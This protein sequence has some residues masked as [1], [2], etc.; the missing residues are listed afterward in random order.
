MNISLEQYLETSSLL[1]KALIIL[2]NFPVVMSIHDIITEKLAEELIQMFILELNLKVYS[3]SSWL[4][5]EITVSFLKWFSH[6]ILLFV[7]FWGLKS[8]FMEPQ[9]LLVIEFISIGNED[10]RQKI[11]ISWLDELYSGEFD[12]LSK[13]NLYSTEAGAPLLPM[14]EGRKPDKLKLQVEHQPDED[15]LQVIL[16]SEFLYIYRI[17]SI[18]ATTRVLIQIKCSTF[19]TC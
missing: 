2:I 11:E 9:R 7:V 15:V 16:P 17:C 13:C 12:D 1:L 14:L 18:S 19:L 6:F 3:T 4:L 8:D 5:Q 10:G